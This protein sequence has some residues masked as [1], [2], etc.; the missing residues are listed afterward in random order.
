MLI[1]ILIWIIA[2]FLSHIVNRSTSVNKECFHYMVYSLKYPH[3][4]AVVWSVCCG[5][6]VSYYWISPLRW[7]L[8]WHSG[9]S[10]ITLG[11][12]LNKPIS[13]CVNPPVIH[14]YQNSGYLLN[15][16]FTLTDV[17]TDELRM[18]SV[19]YKR[20]QK[21]QTFVKQNLKYSVYVEKLLQDIMWYVLDQ[22]KDNSI[23]NNFSIE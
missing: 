18:T 23:V 14:N 20:H 22:G 19:K 16:T 7:L 3:G 15:I 12:W 4:F 1:E 13:N 11:E 8:H 21:H 5:F 6:T 17:S 9:K 2:E 10:Y